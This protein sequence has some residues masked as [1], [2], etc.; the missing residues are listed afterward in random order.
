[1]ALG[2]E[3]RHVAYPV[4]MILAASMGPTP[5]ISVRVVPEASTSASMRP[6]RSAIFRSSVRTSPKISEANRRRRRPE[7]PPCALMPRRMRAAQWAESVP[8]TPPGTS[9]RRSLCKRFSARVRSATRSS[10]LSE[11]RRSTSEAASGSTTASRQ[12]TRQMPT[13]ASGVLHRPTPLVVALRPAFEG[14]QAGAILREGGMLDE[15]A[16]GFVDHRDGDRRLV[17]IDPDEHF[18]ARTHLRFGRTSAIGARRTFRL[19]AVH[20]PLLSHSA[21]RRAPVRYRRG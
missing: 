11:S 3:A 19:R 5:K 18:H 20:T 1:V 16:D 10:R 2:R 12:P 8:A 17:G 9:S 14:H 4:P 21:R 7:A 15:L 6:F 13:K